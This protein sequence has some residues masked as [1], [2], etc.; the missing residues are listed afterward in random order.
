MGDAA[1]RRSAWTFLTNHAR[2]LVAIAA[3]PQVRIRDIAQRIGITERA[4]QSIVT[5]LLE[6]GH[7]ERVREGRRSRYAIVPGRRLRHSSQNTIPVQAL[8]DLFSDRAST[9]PAPA[10]DHRVNPHQAKDLGGQGKD[11]L[12]PAVTARI[13]A[14]DESRLRPVN[15]SITLGRWLGELSL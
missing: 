13:G 4:A 8:I 14:G 11:P 12:C 7:V 3:D 10:T 15:P 6:A 1:D 2:V 5:D 9:R